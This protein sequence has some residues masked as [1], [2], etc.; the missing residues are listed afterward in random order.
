MQN[1]LLIFQN[2][3]C[4]SAVIYSRYYSQ[5]YLNF[6]LSQKYKQPSELPHPSYH[7]QKDFIHLHSSLCS[8]KI[9]PFILSDIG[10]GIVEV[11]VKDW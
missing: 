2:L 8:E 11:E 1:L 7:Q 3:S 9:V 5:N 10:E 6:F 4:R